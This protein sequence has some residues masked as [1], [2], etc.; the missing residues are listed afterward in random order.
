[1]VV[2]VDPNEP[3]HYPTCPFLALTGRFCPGCGGMRCVRALV[4]GDPH[5][6][7]GFNPLAVALLPL[8]AWLWLRWTTRELRGLPRTSVASPWLLRALTAVILVVWLVRN[9]PCGAALAP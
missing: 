3:G 2:V 9:L 8:F 5:A 1:M 7:V 6:A 4:T